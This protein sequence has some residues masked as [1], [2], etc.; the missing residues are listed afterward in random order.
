MPLRA[1]LRRCAVFS[2]ALLVGLAASTAALAAQ[3]T[4]GAGAAA[5]SAKTTRTDCVLSA[6][7]YHHVNPNILLAI[8]IVESRMRPDASHLNAN[9]TSDMGL[10]QIN[11]VHLNELAKYGVKRD[12]LYDG[13]KNVY[14]GAWILRKRLN[15]YG[16][17]WAAIGAYHSAT[18]ALRDAY[19]ARVHSTVRWLLDSG[20]AYPERPVTQAAR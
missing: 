7:E 19:A 3:A 18:P 13:C 6:A 12:D 5:E 8:A 1:P 20:Y 2:S 4:N 14:T 9:G 15:E 11:S 10:M 17:T 16:N